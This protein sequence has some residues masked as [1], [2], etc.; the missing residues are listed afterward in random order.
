MR[1]TVRA[2]LLRPGMV[3]TDAGS[4]AK[5][6]RGLLP[7]GPDGE[8]RVARPRLDLPDVANELLA[9]VRYLTAAD[10]PLQATPAGGISPWHEPVLLKALERLDVIDAFL[11]GRVAFF[12]AGK[13]RGYG[14]FERELA[15]AAAALDNCRADTGIVEALLDGRPPRDWEFELMGQT[16]LLI[17]P[18]LEA[19]EGRLP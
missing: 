10:G 8:A 9:I 5:A 18:A 17:Y 13:D 16:A 1:T 12:V 4:T 14:S 2:S 15:V 19:L 3:M 6:P 11:R 7:S